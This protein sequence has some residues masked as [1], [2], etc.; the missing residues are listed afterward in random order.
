MEGKVTQFPKLFGNL[1][2]LFLKN[3][4]F[5]A[6]GAPVYVDWA[7]AC[8]YCGVYDRY[9]VDKFGAVHAMYRTFFPQSD[10]ATV[11]RLIDLQNQLRLILLQLPPD[12]VQTQHLFTCNGDYGPLLSEFAK[13][14]TH[15]R[16]AGLRRRKV[17]RLWNRMLQRGLVRI[18]THSVVSALPAVSQRKSE[19]QERVHGGS[20][21]AIERRRITR[22]E[23]D[24]AAATLSAAE[25]VLMDVFRRAGARLLPMGPEELADYFFR[26]W[27]PGL[28]VEG[29]MRVQYDYHRMPFVDAW[30]VQEVNLTRDVLQI[31][32]YYHSVVSL[33]GLPLETRPRDIER[34]TVN[35]PFRDVRVTLTV[36]RTDKLQRMERLRHR[37]DAADQR[38][39][40][41]LNAIEMFYKPH[42]DRRESGVH[43]IEAWMQIEEAQS[44]LRDLR[45]GEDE[46][47]EIQ[48]TV[49]LW[50][51][52]PEE[53][54]RRQKL[55]L[56]RF[57][58]LA[59]AR[60]WVERTGLLPVLLSDM[61]CVYAPLTRPFF[62]RCRMAADLMPICRGLESEERPVF[63][64]GNTTGGLVGLDLEDKRN[65]GAS[66]LYIS[67]VKGSGKS[68]LAQLI[69][70]RAI[71]PESVVIIIDKG[72]S[73]DRLVQWLGGATVRLDSKHPIC[74]N[75]FEVY[76][77]RKEVESLVEPTASELSRVVQC[78]EILAVG[79]ND[80][81][82]TTAERNIIETVAR[83]TFS[84]AVKARA[85]LVTL[86][87]FCKQLSYR[88]DG[89]SLL[90][91][92]KPFVD[93]RY[94]QWFNG[95]TQLHLKSKIVHFDFEHVS[96]DEGLARVLIPIATLFV[97]DLIYTYPN[98]FKILVFGEMWQHVNNEYTANLIIDAFKTYRKKRC[99]VIGESQAILDLAD[100]PKVAKAVIQNVDTWLMLPQ[101][102]EAHVEFAVRELE[103]TEG[104]RDCLLNLKQ[105]SRVHPHGAV[106][107]W[108][109]AFYLR[110]RGMDRLSG[111]VR[112][113]M[114]PEEYWI[115]TTTPQDQPVWQAALDAFGGHMGKAVEFLA[116]RYPTGV[117]AEHDVSMLQREVNGVQE[118]APKPSLP[119]ESTPELRSSLFAEG[120]E[121]RW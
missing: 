110:G 48:L 60:G 83:Q 111:I 39:K 86:D 102:S 30:M 36:R 6:K 9:V 105:R 104:Q 121:A 1:R 87:D 12:I 71:T 13:I 20:T 28:A 90:E 64:F 46:L 16:L 78:L 27:N 100:N 57:G 66:M 106:E 68:A 72:T 25:Q 29:G 76:V 84:N 69:L 93:G 75:P 63:L 21:A 88:T 115:T 8:P 59:R 74:F 35:L 42:D 77:Q 10:I 117:L 85:K 108:R 67:G 58:D 22:D 80:Q 97:S 95:A 40:L 41:G 96:R 101:G 34:L 56:N 31:G 81:P 45:S 73:Y 99:A 52:D 103:L 19:W 62:V 120:K 79:K 70:L 3:Q 5:T 116:R 92:L 65:E 114:E 55:L 33:V 43:N 38:M 94:R 11:E 18:E 49:H 15:P 89:S 2:R 98:V 23:F 107:M 112:V 109:E 82:L 113:E 4:S 54:R 26:L 91:R 50:H 61:P 51:K 118:S 119:S 7:D 17:H 37:I 14:P 24:A 47:V 53:V 32:D 44:L